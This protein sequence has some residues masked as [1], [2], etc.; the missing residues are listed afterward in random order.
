MNE[1]AAPLV[2]DRSTAKAHFLSKVN[3]YK[4]LLANKWW[5]LT[6]GMALGVAVAGGLSWFEAVT[7]TSVGQM[8]VNIKLAIPEGSVYTEEL[9]NFLGTQTEL[10]RSDIVKRRANGRVAAQ[11]PHADSQPVALKVNAIPKTTIF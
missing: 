10:M 5:L 4:N 2:R 1:Q 8:I 7:Y 6:L 9:S 3:R 11:R